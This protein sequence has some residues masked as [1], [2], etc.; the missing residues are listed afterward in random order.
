MSAIVTQYSVPPAIRSILLK[1]PPDALPPTE[2][3]EALQAELRLAKQRTL[4]RA[5]KAGDDL[6][7]I[8]ESMRRLRE[9]EKG[10]GKAIEKVKK[11]RGFTP[12]PN[13]EDKRLSAQPQSNPKS[14][15][16]SMPGSGA[17]STASTP[18]YDPRKTLADEAR[19]KKKKR[20][21]DDVSDTETEPHKTRKTTPVPQNTQPHMPPPV[22]VTKYP[23]S[24][25]NQL[26]KPA[27]GPDFTVP[28]QTVSMPV[29]PSAPAPPIPGPSKPTEVRDDFSKAKQPSQVLITTFYTSIEPWLRPIK[30][31]D[32]GFLEHTDDKVEPFIMPKLGRHY[33]EVWE[34]EDIANYGKALPGT[35]AVRS[36][37][38]LPGSS[39]MAPLPRWEP[40]QLQEKDLLTEERGHGPLTERLVSAMIPMQNATEWKGVKAAEE[41]MEGRPGTNGAAAQAARDKMN[42]ADLE[43][44]VRNVM[45][46]HG[47][48]NEV[49][50]YSEAVD[51]PI[52]TA[53]RHA[54]AELR[55]VVAINKTRRARLAAIA[56][57][58]LGYQFY[59]EDREDL[60]KCISNLY[61]KLQKKSEGP[62]SHKKKKKV[63][64]PNGAANA[65]NSAAVIAPSPAALGLTPTDDYEL[66][67]PEQLRQY[68]Q[69]RRRY[70]DAVGKVFEAKERESPGRIY[71]LPKTSIYEGI[72][73]EVQRE[74]ERLGPSSRSGPSLGVAQARTNNGGAP[75]NSKGK[76]RA[77]TE[78]VPMELG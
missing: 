29:K 23:S 42:V 7:T 47:F 27:A 55:K 22:K 63:P 77:R 15:L 50:D 54:Q 41:A 12:L 24:I 4:E 39:S 72:D 76:G 61:T 43:E 25:L 62:K 64:E 52:A 56:R 8:E 53:L 78:D 57:D 70:V 40:S 38:T 37:V 10:K 16:P 28:S 14:R 32:I 67:V 33:S 45:R 44:R 11:E 19:K 59:L 5:K 60:D 65:L 34:E 21:R 35:A 13:G 6:R 66:N 73:E 46:F 1:N 2:E 48:L 68:V 30:E 51:D 69:T 74:L 17:H 75:F 3:L 58:R 26:S 18:S 36:G 9:K 71:G 31:E 20:K 49:P